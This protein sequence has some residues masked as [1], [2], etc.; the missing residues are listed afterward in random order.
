MKRF[1]H[2][3]TA[4]ITGTLA[5]GTYTALGSTIPKGV[6]AV[7]PFSV[8]KYLGTW[9]EIARFDFFFERGLSKTTANYSMND[10]GSIRVVNRGYDA[11]KNRWKEA[12]GKAKFVGATDIAMLKVSFFGPFYSGYNVIALDD[13]YRYAL[14]VGKNFNYMW[15]LSRE[16]TMPQEMI[17]RYAEMAQKLG[18][19]TSRLIWV[20]Q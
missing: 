10:D 20:E 4:I 7:K 5:C 1:R 6:K 9:Y 14:V 18:F 12:E 3:F 16:K 11:A 8:Q 13:H 17:E 15:L 2:I 19:D